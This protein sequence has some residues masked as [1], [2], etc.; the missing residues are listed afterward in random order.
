V[1]FY[2]KISNMKLIRINKPKNKNYGFPKRK[3]QKEN[4]FLW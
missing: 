1:P 4:Y 3:P 2:L